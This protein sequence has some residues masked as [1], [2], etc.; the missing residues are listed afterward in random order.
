MTIY[1]KIDNILGKKGNG[2]KYLFD[3]D[4]RT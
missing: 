4:C 3:F 2:E 1:F